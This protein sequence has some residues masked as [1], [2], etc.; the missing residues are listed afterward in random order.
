MQALSIKLLDDNSIRAL[1][2]LPYQEF[3]KQPNL[4]NNQLN[5]D[6]ILDVEHNR[7]PDKEK[8]SF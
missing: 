7:L 4:N 2:S 1:I 5:I 3:K 8:R 6:K